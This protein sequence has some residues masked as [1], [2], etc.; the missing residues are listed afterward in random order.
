MTRILLA[1]LLFALPASADCF[2]VRHPSTAV[3]PA[4]T[5][6]RVDPGAVVCTAATSAH[7][8]D[9]LAERAHDRD[10]A[11]AD[12]QLAVDELLAARIRHQVEID[13]AA[14]RI[15]FLEQPQPT[16]S[17]WPWLGAGMA[18]GAVAV[19]VLVVVTR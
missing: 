18:A 11:L 14:A 12:L 5:T 9:E 17:P 10:V 15:A 3:D 19:L 8:R 16:P 13:A 2:T 7:V 4:G 1:C 6:R